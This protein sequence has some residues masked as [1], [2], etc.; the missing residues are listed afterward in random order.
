MQL[1]LIMQE[2]NKLLF[3]LTCCKLKA[4]LA[5]AEIK[6]KLKRKLMI[7][8]FKT[9]IVVAIAAVLALAASTTARG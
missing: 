2:Q 3:E 1:L 7:K 9:S 4:E 8:E 5:A 6:V